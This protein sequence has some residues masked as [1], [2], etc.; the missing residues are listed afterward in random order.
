MEGSEGGDGRRPERAKRVHTRIA[1]LVETAA[2][3]AKA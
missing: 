1:M 2:E 3:H